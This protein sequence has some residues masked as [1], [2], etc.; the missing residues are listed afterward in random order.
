MQPGSVLALACYGL[1]PLGP[2]C[3]LP[4][5][6]AVGNDECRSML[7]CTR[8]D[9]GMVYKCEAYAV[10]PS[11]GKG[12]TPG[13]AM[14]RPQDASTGSL[15]HLASSAGEARLSLP[16]GVMLYMH[17]QQPRGIQRQA[18]V[19]PVQTAQQHYQ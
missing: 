5:R 19:H 7:S 14:R 9:S 13:H 3:L 6:L 17:R 12:Q 15:L 4:Q 10:H 8:R 11:L 16:L 1:R 18:E 2:P